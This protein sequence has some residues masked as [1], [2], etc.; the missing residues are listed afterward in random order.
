MNSII[1][2]GKVLDFRY[3]RCKEQKFV[4]N[5]FIGDIFI[6]QLFKMKRNNW[7][8]VSFYRPFPLCP[9][10]GFVNKYYASEFLLKINGFE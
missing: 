7:S 1:V 4:Y 10:G 5:F 8:A 6:G 3:T 9:L 2:N